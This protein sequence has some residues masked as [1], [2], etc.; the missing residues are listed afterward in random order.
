MTYAL[1]LIAFVA[2]YALRLRS[3]LSATALLA[4]SALL[5]AELFRD[6]SASASAVWWW[7]ILVGGVL[8]E[9]TWALNYTRLNTR[10]GAVFLFTAFYVLTGLIQQHLWQRLNRR[11][12]GEFLISLAIGVVV[13][14]ALA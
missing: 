3:I 8:S 4:T 12:V 5:G 11:A 9:M 14:A 6:T 10:S 2:I 13:A 1:A 7:S